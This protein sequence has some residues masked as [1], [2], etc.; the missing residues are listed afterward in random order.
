ME[1]KNIIQVP[2]E[3]SYGRLL[4]T[5]ANHIMSFPFHNFE[6]REISQQHPIQRNPLTLFSH[7]KLKMPGGFCFQ[8]AQS[9]YEKLV[10]QGFQVSRCIARVLNGMGVNSKELLALPATHMVLTVNLHQKIFL[11]DAGLGTRAPRIPIPVL[12]DDCIFSEGCHQYRLRHENQVFVLE[13]KKSDNGWISLI[14]TDLQPVTETQINF[15]LQQLERFPSELGIRDTKLV[16]GMVTETGNK[17]LYWDTQRKQFTFTIENESG[18]I[19]IE[20][21]PSAESASNIL[22]SEFSMDL[23]TEELKRYCSKQQLPLPKRRWSGEFS[24]DESELNKMSSNLR[25]Y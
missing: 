9:L 1:R 18:Q 7:F 20:I 25:F 6:L 8:S 4:A 15:S 24:I 2:D 13:K 14:Q 16:I 21:L 17:S 23:C 5:Y 22:K 11:L 12:D 3:L 10:G 19:K